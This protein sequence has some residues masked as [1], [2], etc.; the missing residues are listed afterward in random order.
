[1]LRDH[2]QA[3]KYH[4][5]IEGYNGRMDAIQAGILRVK[6]GRLDDWNASRREAAGRYRELFTQ[7]GRPGFAPKEPDWA[8]SVYHLYVI[9]VADR[10]RVIRH[11][12][13]A[14]IGTGIHYPVPLHLQK[15]YEYLGYKAGDFPVSEMVAPELLSLPMFPQMT[16]E[17]QDRVVDTITRFV[18]PEKTG[19]LMHQ[20]GHAAAAE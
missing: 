2:G 5:H 19:V 18:V 12:V 4:H 7:Q 6:I 17:Q 3:R 13:E 11:L 14:N 9:R 15:A 16:A 20:L 1:M 8:K 10:E